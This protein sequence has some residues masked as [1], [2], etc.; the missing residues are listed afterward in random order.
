M[1][2]EMPATVARDGPP[3][4][5]SCAVVSRIWSTLNFAGRPISTAAYRSPVGRPGSR[6]EPARTRW[7][8][9]LASKPAARTSRRSTARTSRRSTAGDLP[10]IDGAEIGRRSPGGPSPGVPWAG[11]G[12]E[13]GR[14]PLGVPAEEV[15]D[16]LGV[17]VEH[18]QPC[19][20]VALDGVEAYDLAVAGPPVGVDAPLVVVDDD[21]V[22]VRGDDPR[23]DL[24]CL[25]GWLHGIPRGGESRVHLQ[26]L[27]PPVRAAVARERR[28]PRELHVRGVDVQDA[29]QV[30]L[31]HRSD[32]VEHEPLVRL[33]RPAPFVVAV[34]LHEH[35]SILG[36]GF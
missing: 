21:L 14:G 29:L 18:L 36:T 26:H 31:L 8:R 32:H 24:P 6:D 17:E 12:Q 23:V 10:A 30:A 27:R 25:L 28:R 16:L 2:S 1:R 22:V 33:H 34:A 7:R 11:G 9:P 35:T 15:C 20:L 13:S 19:D 3:S 4:A 5:T